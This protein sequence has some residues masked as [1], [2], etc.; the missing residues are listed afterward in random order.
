MKV[1]STNNT[2]RVVKTIIYVHMTIAPV[3]THLEF[4]KSDSQR[5]WVKNTKRQTEKGEIKMYTQLSGNE[6]R[7][8]RDFQST[9][10]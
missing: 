9:N 1:I 5:R 2:A 4:T 10:Y 6:K 8:N 3:I 7:V